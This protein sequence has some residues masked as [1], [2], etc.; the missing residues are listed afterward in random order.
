[1]LT[2]HPCTI[3]MTKTD[4]IVAILMPPWVRQLFV[5]IF[6]NND[7]A[8]T[9]QKKIIIFTYLDTFVI[10]LALINIFN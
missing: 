6:L 3:R 4:P 9:K 7:Y 8:Q 2:P 5:Y 10:N 1:M